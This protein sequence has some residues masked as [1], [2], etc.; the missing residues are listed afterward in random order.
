MTN[1]EIIGYLAEYIWE[2]ETRSSE[3]T[4]GADG[5][6]RATNDFGR[7]KLIAVCDAEKVLPTLRNLIDE[8]VPQEETE[9]IEV[10]YT[11]R[12]P[13]YRKED[14][15]APGKL[16]MLLPAN[17]AWITQP[18]LLHDETPLGDYVRRETSAK[19]CRELGDIPTGA[20][21]AY[22]NVVDRILRFTLSHCVRSIQRQQR[23]LDGSTIR[24]LV[25]RLQPGCS[26]QL[27]LRNAGLTANNIIVEAKNRKIDDAS[28][29]YQLGRYL[30]RAGLASTGIL[31]TR[32]PLSDEL[33]KRVADHR[34]DSRGDTVIIPIDDDLLHTF[35]EAAAEGDFLYNE[36]SL[37]ARFEKVLSD[38]R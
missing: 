19:L 25:L 15:Y 20:G 3:V 22:E 11:G 8:A 5:V 23:S 13:S 30:S 7:T 1:D 4:C 37:I 28:H 6:L 33:R 2:S 18:S 17:D 34:H 9:I 36:K 26:L 31:V 29:V 16:W 32:K 35:L 38:T 27:H 24:D 10:Y 12:L 14:Y 21:D